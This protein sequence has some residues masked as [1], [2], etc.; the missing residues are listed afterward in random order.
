MKTFIEIGMF[1]FSLGRLAALLSIQYTYLS[2][3]QDLIYKILSP[4][5]AIRT[6]SIK[7]FTTMHYS[8]YL[9]FPSKIFKCVEIVMYRLVEPA[10]ENEKP[11][12]G[13]IQKN[14]FSLNRGNPTIFSIEDS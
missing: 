12:V 6:R 10:E 11:I 2:P 9:I 7:S 14:I 3:S 5:S 1:C 4:L 8:P 13:V